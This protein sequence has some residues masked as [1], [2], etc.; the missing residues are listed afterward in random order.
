MAD[1]AGIEFADRAVSID[2]TLILADLHLGKDAASDVEWPVGERDDVVERFERLCDRFEPDDIVI[3][4]DLLHSFRTIPRLVE[5]T[6]SG[7]ERAAAAAGA[8]VVVLPGNHDT[9]LEVV[10]GGSTTV[11]YN[12]NGTLVCHGH[13]EPEGD[14][15]RY[16]IGHEHPTIEIEGQRHACYLVGV[17]VYRGSDLVVVPAFNRLLKG[18]PINGMRAA[19]FMSPMITDVDALSPVVID[20]ERGRALDFPRLGQFREKL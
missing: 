15:D 14:A 6:I 19:D 3:A 10:W 12:V 1:L 13:V 9:M 8:D 11:E 4:G 18:V 2:D 17:G 20:E 7:L 16:V 5:E